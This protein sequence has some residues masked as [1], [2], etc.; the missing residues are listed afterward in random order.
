VG[1]A[2]HCYLGIDIGTSALKAV[3][4]DADE[5]VMAEAAAPLDTSRPFP[6]ASEQEPEAWWLATL[7]VLDLL[8]RAAPGPYAQIA[9]LGLSGQMHAVV[10][11][12]GDGRALRP[13]ILWNDGRAVAE[14]RALAAGVPEIGSVAGV[15]PMPGLGAPKLKWLS[16]HEPEML[17]AARW[18]LPAK[19]VIRLRLTGEAVTDL[20]EA[21]G[22]L[23]L[24]QARRDWSPAVIAASG[25]RAVQLPRLVEGTAAGGRLKPAV[26]ARLGLR[27]EVVVAGG[28]GDAAAGAIG[29]G[30]VDDG[31]AFV[32]L[33]TSAQLFVTTASYRPAPEQLVHAFAH[34]VPDRWFQVA[35]LLNGASPLA[36]LARLLGTDDVDG[37]LTEVEGS[38]SAPGR[39]LFL[40]YLAG[41]RTPHDDP[42]ARGVLL[43]LEP[44]T[45]R[46]EIVAA[47]LEGVALSLVDARD[48][49]TAA[50]TRIERVGLIG[51]GARSRFWTQLI[52][53]ALGVPV[54]RYRS[55]DV[56]PALGAARLARLAC[57]EGTVASVCR[58]PEIRDTALPDA[59]LHAA[60]AAASA[61]FRRLYRTLRSEF[62]RG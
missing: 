4:V 58:K 5:R 26:A 34:A 56:G 1:D 25:A 8:R 46:L 61:R 33:G 49:L 7:E 43:G 21:A 60:F 28:A 44:T 41:E 40:P 59:T 30:A 23:L 22:L 31:D 32:S 27:P 29:I 48:A 16:T 6:G 52:A 11:V 19:D 55:G 38:W 17:A 53:H 20:S 9:G 14:C 13:A 42:M 18:L 2:D 12:D 57:G 35:A 47:V 39:L 45:S 51:G 50:G 54:E 37:L 36:W 3:L 62:A 24:D 15:P 10:P